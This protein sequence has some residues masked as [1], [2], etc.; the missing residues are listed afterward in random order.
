[1]FPQKRCCAVQCSESAR[2]RASGPQECGVF[3]CSVLRDERQADGLLARLLFQ[4]HPGIV[5]VPSRFLKRKTVPKIGASFGLQKPKLVACVF[6]GHGCRGT[7]FVT[8]I[9]GTAVWSVGPVCAVPEVRLV[10]DGASCFLPMILSCSRVR[11]RG[12]QIL[13][14]VWKVKPQHGK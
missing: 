5:P 11:T 14:V 12:L 13:R 2:W 9:R 1:M 4:D 3:K 6:R 8:D 7:S 10:W